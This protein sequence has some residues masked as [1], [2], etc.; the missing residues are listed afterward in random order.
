MIFD[1]LF[2][3]KNPTKGWRRT[4][5]L[6]LDFDLEHATLNGVRLRDNRDG[7]SFLGPVE[8][9]AALACRD[10]GYSSL[11]L[12][13][14]CSD[15]DNTVDCFLLVQRDP[16]CPEYQPFPGRC[17]YRGKSVSLEQFSEQVFLRD[18][19]EPYWRDEDDEEIILFYEFPEFEWQVELTLDGR[20]K[21]LLIVADPAMADEA[22]R[23]ACGVTKP[24]PP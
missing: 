17:H 7:L 5:D 3:P 18:F 13:I 16:C 12:L 23:I 19:G 8:D 9:R 15:K 24:W 11:G 22:E 6:Q 10:L 1:F 21:V 20:F 4:E 14:G 2:G